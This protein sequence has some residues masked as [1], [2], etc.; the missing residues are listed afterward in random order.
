MKLA[1]I[2]LLRE[3]TRLKYEAAEAIRHRLTRREAD[4]EGWAENDGTARVW[5][6]LRRGEG[7]GVTR[8]SIETARAKAV[9]LAETQALE[10]E[11]LGA[12]IVLVN[13]IYDTARDV[14]DALRPFY[15]AT[16][17]D[18]NEVAKLVHE[19]RSAD[20]LRREAR[21]K[22]GMLD[23][24]ADVRATLHEALTRISAALRDQGMDR[25]EAEQSIR[26]M[27]FEDE[28]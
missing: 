9:L 1:A 19:V 24:A 11:D 4:V 7:Y 27:V 15:E 28:P 16:R 8:A 13:A 22:L 17:G 21:F 25:H 23:A 10:D 12:E 3:I 18:P 5:E 14:L 20:D 26:E 2:A 6:V